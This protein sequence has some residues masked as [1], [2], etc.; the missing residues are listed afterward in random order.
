MR[1]LRYVPGQHQ[2]HPV[3]NGAV[4]LAVV[5]FLLIAGFGKG[6]PFW[7]D[8]RNTVVVE[9]AQATS[10]RTG[11]PVRVAGI[12]V[13]EVSAVRLGSGGRGA[14]VEVKLDP[15]QAVDLRADASAHLYWRTLLG[16]NMYLELLPGSQDRPPLADGRIP[17]QRTSTQVEFDQLLEPFDDGGRRALRTMTGEF[18]AGFGRPGDVRD[19]VDAAAPAARAAAPGLRALRGTATGDLTALVQHASRALGALAAEDDALAAT[20]EHGAVT[21]GVTAS[22]RADLMRLVEVAPG[23][24]R[25]TRRT[26]RRLRGTLD[27]LDP[28]AD[29]LRPGAR[30]LDRTVAA[31]RPTLDA[32]TPLLE[33][34]RPLLDRLQPAVRD[35]ARAGGTGPRLFA[36]LDP[37]LRRTADRIVPW[38]ERRDDETKLRNLESIGPWFAGADAVASRFDA[39]GFVLRMQPGV[40]LR[41]LDSLP[42]Q[43]QL[44]DATKAELV[45]C[46]ALQRTLTELMGRGGRR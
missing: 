21:L 28:L 20:V 24:E 16:R 3:R 18:A 39:N 38:L 1:R 41:S 13:G 5:A 11:A 36:A 10:L 12:D 6:I 8:S 31:L 37:T 27:R 45:R 33:R 34:T 14:D 40:S 9:L 7:P 32:A 17:A 35:L 30:R 22:R 4:F 2:P 43:A 29:A 26:M 25:E 42:C 46:D 15:G 23:A 19:T 44:T